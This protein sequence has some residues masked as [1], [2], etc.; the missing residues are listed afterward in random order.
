[1][2]LHAPLTIEAG[3]Q[4]FDQFLLLDQRLVLVIG[5]RCG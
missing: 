1:M 5:K 2:A 4:R 3:G